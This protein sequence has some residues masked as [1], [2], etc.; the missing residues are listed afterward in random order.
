MI[1]VKN[2]TK[3]FKLTKEG[4]REQGASRAARELN[5]VSDLSF[6]CQPGLFCFTPAYNETLHN[7]IYGYRQEWFFN[8]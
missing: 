2:L 5:A 6:T 3:T 7:L 8:N 4:R 1:E